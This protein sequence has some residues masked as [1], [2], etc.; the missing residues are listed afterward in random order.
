MVKEEKLIEQG[1]RLEQLIINE[2]L[3]QADFSSKTG[4]KTSTLN[5]VIKGRNDI[6]TMVMSQILDAFPFFSEKWI[7]TGDGEMTTE[8]SEQKY[9]NAT[10]NQNLSQQLPLFTTPA[11]R[12]RAESDAISIPKTEA[13]IKERKILKI[14]V[15]YEDNTFET[16]LQEK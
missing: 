11:Y 16:F 4:I 5:H 7:R 8:N 14:I 13:K 10:N 2:G 15:Y 12:D 6:S 1:R 9:F 3:S